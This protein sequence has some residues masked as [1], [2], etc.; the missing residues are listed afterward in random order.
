MRH[1]NRIP[2]YYAIFSK[3]Q[4]YETKTTHLRFQY[5]PVNLNDYTRTVRQTKHHHR[6]TFGWQQ[7]CGAVWPVSRTWCRGI[8]L[9]VTQLELSRNGAREQ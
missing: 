8:F 9:V 7:E 4:L 3:R 1:Q 5:R 2:L 6:Q